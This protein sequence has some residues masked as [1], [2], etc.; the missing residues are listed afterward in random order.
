MSS[1]PTLDSIRE[2]READ[3]AKVSRL[4]T[5][6]EIDY[7]LGIID[8]VREYIEEIVTPYDDLGTTLDRLYEMV[9]GTP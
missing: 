1:L 2:R 7:L 4:A 9:G 8:G 3:R 6:E 5:W